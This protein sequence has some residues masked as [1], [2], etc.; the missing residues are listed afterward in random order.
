[1][2]LVASRRVILATEAYSGTSYAKK[3]SH[4]LKAKNGDASRFI[5]SIPNAYRKG[6][7]ESTPVKADTRLDGLVLQLPLCQQF[8]IGPIGFY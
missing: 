3:L 4:L 8:A 5:A 6:N 1:V 7:C 2:P